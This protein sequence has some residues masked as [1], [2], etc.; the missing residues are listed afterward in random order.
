[1]LFVCPTREPQGVGRPAIAV[2]EDQI[3]FLRS[4]HFSWKKLQ[5]YLALVKVLYAV[6]EE[7]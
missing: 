6:E 2:N 3:Q 5:V 1:M 7:G 4:L